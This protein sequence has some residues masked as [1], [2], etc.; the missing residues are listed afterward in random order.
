M[1]TKDELTRLARQKG[2]RDI[3]TM[4]KDYALVWALKA[5]Y[6][7]QNLFDTLVFKG[8]TCLSKVY[9]ENYRL[10]EDLDFTIAKKPAI[11][12]SE[13][14]N[15][16]IRALRSVETQGGPKLTLRENDAL[17]NKG[18]LGFKVT[19]HGPLGH[20]ARIKLEVSLEEHVVFANEQKPLL[21][22]PYSDYSGFSLNCYSIH[23]IVSEKIR[24]VIQRGKSRDY[25]DVW[26]LVTNP[27]LTKL[28]PTEPKRFRK[29]VSE[30]CFL[31]KISYRPELIFD[32]NRLK[33]AKRYWDTELARLTPPKLLPPFEEVIDGLQAI[34]FA[35]NELAQFSQDFQLE[36]M[37][38]IFRDDLNGPLLQRGF[39]LLL[40]NLDSKNKKT[41]LT[42]LSII[43]KLYVE[44]DQ[45][46]YYPQNLPPLSVRINTLL[47]DPDKQIR[48][49]AQSVANHLK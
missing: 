41:V 9:A 36:H 6:T 13:I 31:N 40:E 26:Q 16:L 2:I 19:Y 24:A 29:L 43:E 32:S 23:E 14:K 48:E 5:I 49:A 25:Y 28:V 37:D 15:E 27:S 17:T 22:Q 12:P 45:R 8:G 33:E 44:K 42:A 47:R 11:Q 30:K 21:P 18:Y 3:A 1:I 38:N 10:S 20:N 34:F 4:E 39:E 7:N 46:D 35:E